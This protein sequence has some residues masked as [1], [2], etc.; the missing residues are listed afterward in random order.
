MTAYLLIVVFYLVLM[1]EHIPAPLLPSP[2]FVVVPFYG[3]AVP[4]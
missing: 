3:Y 4:R 1:V 2:S